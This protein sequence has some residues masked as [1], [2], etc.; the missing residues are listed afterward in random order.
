MVPKYFL[1]LLLLGV[2]ILRGSCL[3][4]PTSASLSTHSISS[5]STAIGTSTTT[6]TPSTTPLF[7]SISSTPPDLLGMSQVNGIYGPGSWAGWYITIVASWFRLS[8]DPK[9]KLDPNTWTYLLGI[10]WAAFDLLRHVHKFRQGGQDVNKELGTIGAAFTVLW[11][12]SLH[13]FAQLWL[14]AYLESVQRGI[15]LCFGLL[16]PVITLSVEIFSLGSL[17]ADETSSISVPA[18]YY[19]G[20]S[21]TDQYTIVF[22]ACLTGGWISSIAVLFLLTIIIGVI[23]RYSKALTEI[24]EFLGDAVQPVVTWYGAI[25][26]LSLI[27]IGNISPLIH[28]VPRWLIIVLAL[29]L[30][31]LVYLFYPLWA[32]FMLVIHSTVY[33]WNILRYHGSIVSQSCFFMPCSPQSIFEWD[34]AFALFLGIFLFVGMEALPHIRK[35]W[36]EEKLFEQ[37]VAEPQKSLP[38]ELR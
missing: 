36:K 13:A 23:A 37:Y 26:F 11:W 9:G 1:T 16:M 31:V 32:I 22:A 2:L 5:A 30:L 24:L 12:G 19:R 10:N 33:G 17:F 7:L 21:V 25:S 35:K 3:Y 8:V 4:L 28:L 6:T 38:W 27:I 18:L 29:P 15:T 34:Q 20:M 14:A